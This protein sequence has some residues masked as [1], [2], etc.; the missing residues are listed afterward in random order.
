MGASLSPVVAGIYLEEK[1]KEAIITTNKRLNEKA[2]KEITTV[3]L[4]AEYMLF[5]G[6]KRAT[7]QTEHNTFKKKYMG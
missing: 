7:D 2:E 1:L 6:T 4:Y 3:I 5:I